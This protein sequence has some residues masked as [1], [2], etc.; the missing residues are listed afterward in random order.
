MAK[1][2]IDWNQL[3]R[4]YVS[5]LTT[6]KQL[7]AKYGVS[8]R[9]VAYH[10]TEE[11]WRSARWQFCAKVDTI[12]IS[13]SADRAL[14]NL[15]QLNADHL[16][17]SGELRALIE[18]RL[19]SRDE[20]GNLVPHSSLTINE[21]S[22][23]VIAL[24]LLYRIDRLAMGADTDVQPSPRDRFSEMSDQELEEELAQVRKRNIIH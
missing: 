1:R 12:L 9:S 3:R 6:Y 10:G 21:V 8:T 5:T 20:I 16:R 23:A 15:Q 2:K 19:G 18:S 17:R 24:G 7:G 13:N 4:E 22:R 14:M 11:D